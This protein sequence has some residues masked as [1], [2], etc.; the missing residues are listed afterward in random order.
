MFTHS[1]PHVLQLA[2]K[3]SVLYSSTVPGYGRH[4]A[5]MLCQADFTARMFPGELNCKAQSLHVF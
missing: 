1:L 5:D 4:I 3:I 2:Q